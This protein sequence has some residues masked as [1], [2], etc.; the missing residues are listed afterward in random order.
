M[1]GLGIIKSVQ[2]PLILHDRMQAYAVGTMARPVWD[3]RKTIP[4]CIFR[5][6]PRG[7]SGVITICLSLAVVIICRTALAPPCLVEP[8]TLE[9]PTL[10][11]MPAM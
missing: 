7:P 1:N 9:T 4:L 2:L 3:A 10:L 5:R 8:R 11:S 6:G